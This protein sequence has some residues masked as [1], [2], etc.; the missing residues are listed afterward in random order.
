[1]PY[2]LAYCLWRIHDGW[3][4]RWSFWFLLVPILSILFSNTLPNLQENPFL[5]TVYSIF[6]CP[7]FVCLFPLPIR[8][9]GG[10]N[11]FFF[12][13]LLSMTI[14]QFDVVYMVSCGVA[15]A[16]SMKNSWNLFAPFYL[17]LCIRGMMSLTPF[18][19]WPLWVRSST[20][21]IPWLA[22]KIQSSWCSYRLS[23]L[24]L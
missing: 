5:P 21:V 12:L 20:I 17:V 10:S 18:H 2:C 7:T 24:P 1:M 16:N 11:W 8:C 22:R 3:L 14:Q 19:H 9:L 23:S 15:S 13:F 4:S 6:Y